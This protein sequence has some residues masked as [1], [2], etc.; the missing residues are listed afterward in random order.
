[1]KKYLPVIFALFVWIPLMIILQ[2]QA[3][4]FLRG[5]APTLLYP[6]IIGGL[7]GGGFVLIFVLFSPRLNCPQCGSQLPRFRKPTS[8]KQAAWGGWDCPVC[9]AQLDRTGTIKKNG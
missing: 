7:S 8:F 2:I 4:Q 6:L 5:S 3:Q 9:H 1:M